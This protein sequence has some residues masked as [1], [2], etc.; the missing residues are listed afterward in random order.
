[1]I[2]L[3][4]ALV[5]IIP[6]VNAYLDCTPSACSSGYTDNGVKCEGSTCVRNC[7]IE[8]CRQEWSQTSSDNNVGWLDNGDVEEN[9]V[10]SSY[11]SSAGKC[12]NFTYDATH[13]QDQEANINAEDVPSGDCDSEA[14]GGFWDDAQRSSPW[15]SGMAD[16]IGNVGNADYNYLAKVMRAHTESYA[17]ESYRSNIKV[18][19]GILCAPNT[20]ACSGIGGISVCDTDCYGRA[21]ILNVHQG[22]Y[23]QTGSGSDD[24][25]YAD[26]ECG[27][28][29]GGS[30]DYVNTNR[31]GTVTPPSVKYIVYE[32]SLINQ[33]NDQ[34]CD[35]THEAPSVK[36]VRVLP[37]Q[38]NAGQDLF[39]NNTY[40]DAENFTEQN[41]TYEWWKNNVN[42]NVNSQILL[43]T[44]LTPGDQWYC[45]VTPG[46]GLLSGVQNQ[47]LNTVTILNATQNPVLYVDSAVWSETGYFGSES[48]I[49]GFNEELNN[50]MDNCNAD[51]QGFCNITLTFSSDKPGVLNLSALGIYYAE[52]F[53]LTDISKFYF[54][55]SSGN[56]VAWFGDAGNI[57]LKGILEQSSNYIEQPN[58][59][60]A[61]EEAGEVFFIMAQNGSMYIDGTLTEN[62]AGTLTSPNEVNNLGIYGSDGSLAGLLN[63]SGYLFLKGTLT[64]N[65]NP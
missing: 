3:L 21:T 9:D 33:S 15:F 61:M 1:M 36:D 52:S 53:E 17:T 20:A 38:P 35:R 28:N 48:D 27:N 51:A 16:Y 58:D 8:V 19:K 54:T 10:S 2:F 44:N 18:N 5:L 30:H 26:I 64:E 37:L 46:D 40:Y 60:F 34:S 43:K 65:G 6:S 63:T 32:S 4:C 13:L 59:L 49:I 57:V 50:V 7:T 42:Q 55:N 14:I 29:A 22:Y 45:K 31:I 39:C 25:L 11:T 12:Y 47:S 41:S 24:T 56:N 23:N 62:F